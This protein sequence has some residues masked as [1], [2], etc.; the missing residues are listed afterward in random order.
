MRALTSR[1]SALLEFVVEFLSEKGFP[2]T[3]RE[4]G[5]GT[6]LANISAVRGHML[7][8]EKKGYI[9]KD[10]EKA[11]SIRILRVPSTFSRLK[12]Q[13]HEFARTDEGVLHKIVYGV[14]LATRNGREQFLGERKRWISEA[15]EQRAIEHGWKFLRKQIQPDHIVL[16]VDIW[17]NHSPE[18]VVSR[19]RQTG[20]RVCSRHAKHFDGKSLW[21]KGYVATTDLG[22][23]DD[24]VSQLLQE[25]HLA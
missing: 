15:L 20:N 21:A 14:A 25:A 8:L 1:Q 10:P 16:V 19:I 12:R 7:A 11:R 2:P 24:M 23:L 3:L 13:L 9:T 18:L 22:C 5:D 6:G 4:I 17:P